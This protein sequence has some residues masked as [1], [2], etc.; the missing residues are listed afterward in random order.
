MYSIIDLHMHKMYFRALYHLN[1]IKALVFHP[2]DHQDAESIAVLMCK[3]III[4]GLR[5]T[6]L[7]LNPTWLTQLYY[8]YTDFGSKLSQ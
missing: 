7:T 5:F 8:F 1:D 4:P 6:R 2:T 3:C